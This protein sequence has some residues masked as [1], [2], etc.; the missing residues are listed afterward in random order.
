MSLSEDRLAEIRAEQDQNRKNLLVAEL[1]SRALRETGA[2]PVVVGGSAVE[3]YTEGTYV[4]GDVDLCFA[5]ARLPTPRERELILGKLGTPLSIRT[6][7]VGDVIV[8]LLG[9]LETSA[10]TPLQTMGGLKLIQIEDLIA[11]RILVATVPKFDAERWAVAR[12]LLRVA[13]KGAVAYD[14]AELRRIADSPDYAI[15]AELRQLVDEINSEPQTP[16][17]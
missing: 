7:R 12:L 14:P 4:S 11:E 5:G 10:R 1:V 9:A 15:A 16:S 8:D 3:F 6:W 17:Q 13:L 2:E